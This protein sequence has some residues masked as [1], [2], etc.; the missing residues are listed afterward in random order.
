MERAEVPGMD[1][2]AKLRE[3]IDRYAALILK[4]CFVCLSDRAQ[5]ED[6]M[7]DTFIKAWRHM[8][9][10]ER[11][12]I[13]NEKAWLLRIAMNTCRD[14]RRTAWFRHVDARVALDDLP[15][16]MTQ[17]AEE[18]NDLMLTVCSLPDRFRQAVL[19]YYYHGMTEQETADVLGVSPASVHRR[20]KKA[21]A[22]LRTALEGGERHDGQ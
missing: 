7:Q 6:A 22:L 2:E 11:K 15:P 5:A 17:T 20:L 1:S 16:G 19:L 3:W 9:D 14:Y 13:E 18:D 4:T 10:L 21:E 8:G 12:H